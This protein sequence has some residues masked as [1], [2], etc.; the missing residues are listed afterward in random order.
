MFVVC[1]D[2][3]VIIRDEAKREQV[4]MNLF[5][6]DRF[7]LLLL[8]TALLLR[9]AYVCSLPSTT[10]VSPVR[11]QELYWALATS[12]GQGE[13]FVCPDVE[14]VDVTAL[15][16]GDSRRDIVSSA[17]Q[18]GYF[19]GIVPL[20]QPTAFW[21]PLYPLII[22][23]VQLVFGNSLVI[24]R[25]FQAILGSLLVLFMFDIAVRLFRN[26]AVGYGAALITAFYPFF[27]YYCGIVMTETLYISMLTAFFWSFLRWYQN[28]TAVNCIVM[29]I[30]LGAVFLT[31]SVVLGLIPMTA[32]AVF[33]LS[34]RWFRGLQQMF[35]FIVAFCL[36][37]SPWVLRNYGLFESVVITPTKGGPTFWARNNPL[38]LEKELGESGFDVS[39]LEVFLG[40]ELLTFPSFTTENE[41]Q[42]STLMF[43]RMFRFIK[44]EPEFYLHLCWYKL[45]WF[46]TPFGSAGTP[47]WQRLVSLVSYG[48]TLI[49]VLGALLIRRDLFRQM[50][51]PLSV[52]VYFIFFHAMINGDTRF[53]IPV[54]VFFIIIASPLYTQVWL[55]I[56]GIVYQRKPS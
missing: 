43:Q 44:E 26:R 13:G 31:R 40:N 19:R 51:L 30:I 25:L 8:L 36:V 38:F 55:W 5:F 12:L 47:F 7:L 46:L 20:G 34:S 53:R 21:L 45:Q 16:N 52:V 2:F 18:E 39:S 11:D 9:I 32:C 6:R 1:P 23:A 50:L 14:P 54:D 3:P 10:F 49:F 24:F 28:R 37:L 41:V 48:T 27:I 42:R 4:M 22:S 33:L 15:P 35:L 56:Y 17:I 29:G